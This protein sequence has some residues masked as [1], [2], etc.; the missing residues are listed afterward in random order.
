LYSLS[1]RSPKQKPLARPHRYR[2]V[3]N[4]LALTDCPGSAFEVSLKMM[5]LFGLKRTDAAAK[6][7]G[8]REKPKPK[9]EEVFAHIRLVGG[10]GKILYEGALNGLRFPENLII[11]K[12]IYFFNDREPCFIHRSAVAARLFGELN[13]LLE[14]KRKITAAELRESSPG[15][16]DEYPGLE[17]IESTEK[18]DT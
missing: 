6:V 16:L 8:S 2:L 15:Y 18:P 14:Q 10:E 13:L 7:S 4:I 12:S 11:A 3:R 17:Y 9:K 1:S 5:N